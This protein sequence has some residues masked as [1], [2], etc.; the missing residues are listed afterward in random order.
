MTAT[1]TKTTFTPGPWMLQEVDDP[2]EHCFGSPIAVVGGEEQV[3]ANCFVIGIPS[4]YG[5]FGKD[6]NA[7]NSRLISA[8]PD[9]YAACK[10]LVADL[11]AHARFGLNESEVSMIRRAEAALAKADGKDGAP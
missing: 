10:E 1:D 6:Q 7:A 2:Q 3:E 8:A 5:P 4:D 11:I 9:L